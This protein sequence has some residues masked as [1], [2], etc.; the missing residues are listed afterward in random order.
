MHAFRKAVAFVGLLVICACG[1]TS[2]KSAT[3]S[4]SPSPAA[5]PSLSASPSP[6]IEN[7]V[8]VGQSSNPSTVIVMRPDGSVIATLPGTGMADQHAVGAYLVVGS[9]VSGKAW[10]VDAAGVVK[11]VAPAAAELLA[12]Y[13]YSPPLVVDSSTAI[14]GCVT[15]AQGC[16]VERVD[17]STG[18]VRTLLTVPAVTGQAA[19]GF[20]SS[21]TALDVSPDGST[22]WLR[23]VSSVAGAW[24]LSI[25]GVNVQ[26]GSVTSHYLPDAMGGRDLAISRD[27]T[28]VAGQEAAGT[29]SANLEIAHLH[30]FSLNTG[31]DSDVEGTAPYVAGWPPPGPPTVVFA[32]D[33]GAVAWWGGFN[34]GDTDYRINLAAIGGTGKPLFRLDDHQPDAPMTAVYW[35][36][37][38]TLVVQTT[39]GRPFSLDA[40]TGAIKALPT[41]LYTLS[42]V[43]R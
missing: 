21:L 23:R 14:I 1:A 31:V 22:V 9:S 20:G 32:P 18:A 11:N 24:R 36:D 8:L 40:T 6:V 25:V 3:V 19:M 17:L 4:P 26:T 5:S 37:P 39:S 10:S 34:N 16:S 43:L 30:V 2:T 27:G 7:P 15:S 13:P 28:S 41:G 29:N 35:L 38:T 42:A 12:A 33:G